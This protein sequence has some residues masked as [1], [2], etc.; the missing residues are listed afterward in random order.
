[1][2]FRWSISKTIL[3]PS[4]G[5]KLKN[6]TIKQNM[7]SKSKSVLPKTSARSRLVGKKLLAP[8][9]GQFFPWTENIQKQQFSF[10][11]WWA[12][13]PLVESAHLG[14]KSYEALFSCVEALPSQ[15]DVKQSR[16]HLGSIRSKVGFFSCPYAYPLVTQYPCTPC[17]S[18][19]SEIPMIP[20]NTK[21]TVGS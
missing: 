9:L 12:N 21:L 15:S 20:S 3:R 13:G 11:P 6:R 10:F 1:M 2:K 16:L 4:G 14:F 8:C 19:V 17:L 7:F 18:C 5:P